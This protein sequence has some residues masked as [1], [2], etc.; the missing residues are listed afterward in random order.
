MTLL[1]FI[2]KTSL[3]LGI[4]LLSFI[5]II[6]FGFYAA[7]LH[8]QLKDLEGRLLF[9]NSLAVRSQE[10]AALIK[11]HEED[12]SAFLACKFEQSSTPEILQSSIPH[13]IEFGKISCL[14]A[15]L[16][17]KGFLSQDVSFSIPCLNDRDIFA[18]LD[19]LINKGPGLFQIQEVT[20][21]RVSALSDEM[22]EKIAAGKPQVL[23]EGKVTATWVHR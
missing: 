18:L 3:S 4:S 16:Q 10:A 21:N 15:D 5:F 2:K 14:D 20:I 13:P 9:L 23:F 19:H 1:Y 8:N 12:F 11:T 17:N 22:L 6:S 7:D